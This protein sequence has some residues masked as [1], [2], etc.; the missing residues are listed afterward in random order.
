VI[1][2][3]NFRLVGLLVFIGVYLHFSKFSYIITTR[4]IVGKM[5]KQTDQWI[6]TPTPRGRCLETLTLEVGIGQK[7]ALS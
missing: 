6:P 3:N 2:Y 4:L 1:F 5:L 7:Q